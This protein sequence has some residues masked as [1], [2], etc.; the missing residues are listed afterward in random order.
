[1][2]A[3]YTYPGREQPQLM[4]VNVRCGLGA[5]VAVL[6]ANGAGKV[7]LGTVACWSGL[8]VAASAHAW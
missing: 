8:C 2:G 7:R 3:S 4:D 1:M 6:G 5:R